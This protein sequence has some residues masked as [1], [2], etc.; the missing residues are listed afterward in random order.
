MG[1][2]N[3]DEIKG[4]AKQATGVALDDPALEREG[5]IDRAAGK[6][7]RKVSET[8]DKAKRFAKRR[9]SKRR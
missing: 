7:K 8:V 2:P 5:K 6:V 3:M 4:R 1:N 9:G